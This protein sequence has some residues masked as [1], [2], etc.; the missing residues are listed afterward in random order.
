[1]IFDEVDAGIGGSA[2]S[3]VGEQ[4]ETLARTHQVLVVTHL[5]Q[6]AAKAA[7]HFKVEKLE[8][9]HR[10]VTSVVKLEGEARVRELA[11]MLSGSD[12]STAMAHAR[13][14]LGLVKS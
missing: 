11:R 5:A 14:L 9:D 8:R 10:T 6:I 2:A 3:A 4:L 12:S 7:H 1:V 13:E